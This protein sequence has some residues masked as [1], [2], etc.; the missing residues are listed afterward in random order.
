MK[1]RRAR[2]GRRV[3]LAN[4]KAAI[5]DGLYPLERNLEA[6]V[7]RLVA[8]GGGIERPRKPMSAKTKAKYMAGA[9]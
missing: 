2:A 1:K 8:G 3:L 4:L 5:R 7:S 9:R 6:V